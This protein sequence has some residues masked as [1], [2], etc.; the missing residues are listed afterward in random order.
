MLAVRPGELWTLL[1][2]GTLYKQ[3]E[4][5]LRTCVQGLGLLR[6]NVVEPAVEDNRN[7]HEIHAAM[8]N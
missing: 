2:G 3:V 4:P 5:R 8:G 1:V 6:G 7:E